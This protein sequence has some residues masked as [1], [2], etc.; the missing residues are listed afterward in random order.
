MASTLSAAARSVGESPCAKPRATPACPGCAGPVGEPNV[1]VVTFRVFV[2]GLEID[3]L[4]LKVGDMGD[5]L[6]AGLTGDTGLELLL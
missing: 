6:Y 4:L 1:G 3:P 5:P 2:V